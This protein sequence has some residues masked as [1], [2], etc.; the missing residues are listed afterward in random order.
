MNATIKFD[1][2]ARPNPGPSAVGYIVSTDD[3]TERGSHHIGEATN[4]QA[5]YHALIQS[6]QTARQ[7]ECTDVVVRGDS[8]L[9]VKQVQ[10][11]WKVNDSE[12]HTLWERV[13]ELAEEFESFDIEHIPREGN[14]EVNRLVDRAFSEPV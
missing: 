2:G 6:L 12:L 8:K 13:R 5:E 3:S 4:N 9:V 10:G 14:E 1:G 7:M 11:E